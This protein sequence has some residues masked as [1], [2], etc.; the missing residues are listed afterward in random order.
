M[1]ESIQAR[2]R[3]GKGVCLFLLPGPFLFCGFNMLKAF[4]K[5]WSCTL[6]TLPSWPG[7]HGW[8]RVQQGWAWTLHICLAQF[9][10]EANLASATGLRS[11]AGALET[12]GSASFLIPRKVA[13]TARGQR[14]T[15]RNRWQMDVHPPQNGAIDYAPWPHQSPTSAQEKA[16]FQA[17]QKASA[18]VRPGNQQKI[19][20][21][22]I[23]RFRYFSPLFPPP[24]PEDASALG[25]RCLGA[26]HLK[27]GCGSKN[28]YQNGLPWY[29]G[30][31][32][33]IYA[34]VP[35]LLREREREREREG[36]IERHTPVPHL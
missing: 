20:V 18:M 11:K 5:K 36:E 25:P 7:S 4:G 6:G 31:H 9:V 32:R 13:K 22:E 19:R 17:A 10:H 12:S 2:A 1:G 16:Q 23:Q 29:R 27:L 14:A 21:A 26:C 3:P 8:N 30:Y 33:Q 35:L 24:P 34:P 15:Y 28:R